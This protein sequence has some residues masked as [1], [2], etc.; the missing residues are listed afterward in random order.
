[1]TKQQHDQLVRLNSTPAERIRNEYLY[2]ENNRR[3]SNTVKLLLAQAETHN[4]PVRFG[5]ECSNAQC[6]GEFQMTTA[7]FE[8]VHAR[9]RV[10]VICPGHE[11]LDIEV[12]VRKY[13][14]HYTV[15]KHNVKEVNFV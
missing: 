2:R 3:I 7:E 14:Q 1:M 8:K 12:I 11:E 4:F 15:R 10:F 5:C 13:P 9:S 6:L